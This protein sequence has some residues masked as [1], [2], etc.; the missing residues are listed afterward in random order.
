M[1]Q[2]A[3]FFASS[4]LITISIIV[5]SAGIIVINNLIH[6]YWKPITWFKYEYHPVY[7][8]PTTGEQMVKTDPTSTTKAKK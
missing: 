6:S 3:V 5:I 4:I 1:D 2:A 7:F 8:D